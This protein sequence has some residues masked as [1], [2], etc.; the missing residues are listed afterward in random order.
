VRGVFDGL[1][2][3]K[4]G[5]KNSSDYVQEDGLTRFND[6]WVPGYRIA[7]MYERGEERKRGL[8]P[9]QQK[10]RVDLDL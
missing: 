6:R 4:D 7:A 9:V 5:D 1:R 3:G 8:G 10:G 2:R